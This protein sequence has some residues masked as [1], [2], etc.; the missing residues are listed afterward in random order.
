MHWGIAV[1]PSFRSS[2]FQEKMRLGD[3]RRLGFVPL[4]SKRSLRATLLM[5]AFHRNNQPIRR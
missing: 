4:S 3:I 1:G 2:E 5:P